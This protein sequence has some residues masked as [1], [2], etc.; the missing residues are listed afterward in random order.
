MALPTE[1]FDRHMKAIGIITVR[2]SSVDGALDDILRARL[3]AEAEKLQHSNAGRQRFECFLKLI[4]GADMLPDEKRALADAVNLLMGLWKDRN[5][6]AHGQYGI[7]T[8]GDGSLSPVWSYIRV[9]KGNGH[10]DP[11]MEPALRTVEHL[12]QHADDVSAA[13]KPLRDFLYRRPAA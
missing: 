5:L 12:T 8:G 7:V 10:P 11:L 4:K 3:P 6:I 13:A 1:A 9:P 2:W